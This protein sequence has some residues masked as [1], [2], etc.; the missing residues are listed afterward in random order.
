MRSRLPLA[1]QSIQTAALSRLETRDPANNYGTDWLGLHQQA[2][3]AQFEV[4]GPCAIS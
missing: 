1:H 3:N 4:S 2:A